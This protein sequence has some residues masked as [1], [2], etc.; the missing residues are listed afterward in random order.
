M[1]GAEPLAGNRA[2]R[3]LRAGTLVTLEEEAKTIADGARTLS[4]GK[5]NWEILRTGLSGIVE[6][7]EDNIKEAVRLVFHFANLKAEPAG[8]LS[9]AVKKLESSAIPL[10][11]SLQGGV[12][13]RFR[14]YREASAYREAGVVF[15]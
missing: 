11:A 8:A 10:L 3:S 7:D 6:V 1:I 5:H 4:L 14:K 9:E 15:R 13:E 2:A 12:A